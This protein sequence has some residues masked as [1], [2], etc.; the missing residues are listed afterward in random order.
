MNDD[1]VIESFFNYSDP[2]NASVPSHFKT[3]IYPNDLDIWPVDNV[4]FGLSSCENVKA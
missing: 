3:V 2:I 4:Y 1:Q